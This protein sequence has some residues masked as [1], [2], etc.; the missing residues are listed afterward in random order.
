MGA[1]SVRLSWEGRQVFGGGIE[2]KK[3]CNF[4]VMKLEN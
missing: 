1:P 2:R 4:L 3:L